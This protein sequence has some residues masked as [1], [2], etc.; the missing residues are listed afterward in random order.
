MRSQAGNSMNLFTMLVQFLYLILYV[1]VRFWVSA[2]TMLIMTHDN[3]CGQETDQETNQLTH[4][5][6]TTFSSTI[7]QQGLSSH[8]HFLIVF[9]PMVNCQLIRSTWHLC[10]SVVFTLCGKDWKTRTRTM[11]TR[12]SS[13]E[14]VESQQPGILKCQLQCSL[15]CTHPPVMRTSDPWA[16]Y[17][18]QC[19]CPQWTI[20]GHGH[21]MCVPGTCTLDRIG[22]V[23]RVPDSSQPNQ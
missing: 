3:L 16:S 19:N 18:H 4:P 17:V 2:L 7:V 21:C 11:N 13:A 20:H 10:P 23:Y 6:Q 8:F 5:V 9:F 14:F 15:E 12:S 1:R 22:P